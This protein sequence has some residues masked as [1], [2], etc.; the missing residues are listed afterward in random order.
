[1]TKNLKWRLGKLPT[2]DEVLKLVN[3]KLITKDEARDI[4][5]NEEVEQER[6][7]DSLK[8]EIKFLREIV[9]KLSKNRNQIVETIRIVEK[10]YHQQ[11]WYQAYNTWCLS[12][13]YAMDG[14]ISI[15]SNVTQ[16]ITGTTG[17][18][19]ANLQTVNACDNQ[20]LCAFNSINTF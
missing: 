8:Q 13:D 4:L 20:L 18:Q 3:D 7:E 15:G 6:D 19:L 10:P 14:S 1:M 12:G 16:T 11:I 5:F 2:P 9:E 17:T